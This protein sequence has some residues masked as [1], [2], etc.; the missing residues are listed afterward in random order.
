MSSASAATAKPGLTAAPSTAAQEPACPA[1]QTYPIT[2]VVYDGKSGQQLCDADI[3][4]TDVIDGRSLQVQ[5]NPA[6]C[7]AQALDA[8]NGDFTVKAARSGFEAA[9]ERARVVKTRCGYDNTQVTLWLKPVVPG[10]EKG[11]KT[12]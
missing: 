8:W 4:M 1:I 2:L 10:G 5:R 11:G 9:E 7:R 3:T 6:T 12:R